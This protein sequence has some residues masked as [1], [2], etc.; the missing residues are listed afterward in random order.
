[1]A[2]FLMDDGTTCSY[3]KLVEQLHAQQNKTTPINYQEK[4]LK[5]SG[6][7]NRIR[8]GNMCIY[9]MLLQISNSINECIIDAVTGEKHFMCQSGKTCDKCLQEWLNSSNW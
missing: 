5:P 1:M 3:D 9:D 6:E 8:V 4:P 7:K 2:K